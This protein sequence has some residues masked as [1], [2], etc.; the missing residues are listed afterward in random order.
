[1]KK[2]NILRFIVPIV[3][4]AVKTVFPPAATAIEIGKNIIEA[5]KEGEK[6]LPH[7]WTSIVTQVIGWGVIIYAFATK[8][9]TVEQVLK[10]IGFE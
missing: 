7:N 8:L 2:K 9:I 1:M 4:G 10:F 6:K 3:R 5:K